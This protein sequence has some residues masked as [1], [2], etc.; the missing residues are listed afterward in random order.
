VQGRAQMLRDLLTAAPRIF[1]GYPV[2][3]VDDARSRRQV[4]ADGHHSGGGL[5]F[6]VIV[7]LSTGVTE[8]GWEG[9]VI[10]LVPTVFSGQPT[11]VGRSRPGTPHAVR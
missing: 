11:P 5:G 1:D 6:A 9:T 7:A 10:A 3:P 2:E 8:S 4:V